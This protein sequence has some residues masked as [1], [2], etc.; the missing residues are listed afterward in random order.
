M[1]EQEG[2]RRSRH[3]EL[4]PAADRS[5]KASGSGNGGK[6]RPITD[7][8]GHASRL[9]AALS[10]ALDA[11]DVRRA[12]I[13]SGEAA[14]ETLL[15]VTSAPGYPLPIAKID[16]S[17]C[18]LVAMSSPLG[19]TRPEVAVVAVSGTGANR[20]GRRIDAYAE[21]G[22]ASAGGQQ[23]SSSSGEAD[24][25]AN[26]DEISL[27]SVSDLWRGLETPPTGVRWWQVWLERSALYE[28]E[29]LEVLRRLGPVLGLTL[30]GYTLT[31]ARRTIVHVQGSA[32]QLAG[33]VG[34]NAL[35][36]EV[37]PSSAA[38]AFVEAS[39][40]LREDLVADLQARTIPAQREDAP[41]VTV[42]DGGILAHHP[43][44]KHSLA[45]SLTLHTEG[46][47][48]DVDGHGTAM[49]GLALY[50]DFA[51]ALGTNF[52]VHL[53]HR[54]ESVRI[55]ELDG[56][57]RCAG[58]YGTVMAEAVALTEIDAPLTRRVYSMSVTDH[59]EVASPEAG[60][61]TAW[62]TTVDALAYGHDVV[63]S[64]GGDVTLLTPNRPGPGRLF[65][66]S[67]GNVREGYVQDHLT[68]CDLTPVEDPA[69]SWNAVTVGAYTRMAQ[70]PAQGSAYAKWSPMASE[71][72]L[73]P[74][75]RTGVQLDSRWPNK[76][77]I[78]MEGGNLLWQS[79]PGGE[80]DTVAAP[81][82]GL[83]TTSRS[84]HQLVHAV[85][86]TSPATAQAA[87][88]AALVKE[89]YPNLSPEAVR[90]LLV[91][92][93]E[94]TPTMWG[95][96]AAAGAFKTKGNKQLLGAL[97]RRYGWGVPG[98]ERLVSSSLHDL[99]LI[100]EEEFL[101]LRA[102]RGQ[103][104]FA[105][106][107]VH[108]LP[109]PV[110]ELRDLGDERVRMRVTLSYFVEPW[111]G[112]QGWRDRFAYPSHE[113]RFDLPR[114][115]EDAAEFQLRVS[116]DAA[117]A[118]VGRA[119]DGRKRKT[120]ADPGWLLGSQQRQR[121]SLCSDLWQGTA[122]DL[123]ERAYLA[124]YPSGGWWKRQNAMD[125]AQVPV[126]YALLISIRAQDTGTD[127]LTP[128]RSEIEA[129]ISVPVSIEL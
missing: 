65:L 127:L 123:A 3:L 82:H 125:R 54:I 40:S 71:G 88:L 81:S 64:D 24:L 22:L 67:A 100:A 116:N 46:L 84:S 16:S 119:A 35:P 104:T 120:K 90:G 25:V 112:G 7:R 114:H 61:P 105:Q 74:F 129:R 103:L 63:V 97:L 96:F 47:A 58:D 60:Q 89:R 52:P 23:L 68:R 121:G 36:V 98:E 26:V 70:V 18:R 31:F 94:W 102:N 66:I 92:C 86:A 1:P 50:G 124:V 14:D 55:L 80:L 42:L 118:E 44:L 27:A 69:Q 62:S 79:A 49:A 72:E 108:S 101:P 85:H 6:I 99:T 95:H 45:R 8:F 43:L 21:S 13:P 34:T 19:K 117:A 28:E 110:K 17:G 83:L 76:P 4:P 48:G 38:E 78:V 10:A 77:D 87:R 29:P 37:R 32:S 109:W 115:G 59:T 12:R 111:V 9:K 11:G 41:A 93:A 53:R 20:L 56:E 91:H 15:A 107:Q 57:P 75:S 113:L 122:N 106:M 39:L 128:I 30:S 126:R 51:A 2:G 33:L 5:F 73:S